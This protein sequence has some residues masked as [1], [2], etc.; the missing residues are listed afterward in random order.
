MI[1]PFGNLH[2][3]ILCIKGIVVL[4]LSSFTTI[5]STFFDLTILS[6]STFITFKRLLT[7]WE[8]TER[9]TPSCFV[10]FDISIVIVTRLFIVM[11]NRRTFYSL[12]SMVRISSSSIL[13]VRVTWEVAFSP[14]FRVVIIELRKSFWAFPIPRRLICGVLLV[15]LWAA[16][17][18]LSMIVRDL[19]WRAFVPRKKRARANHSHFFF[20][21]RSSLRHAH[22]P[23]WCFS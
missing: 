8:R 11:W 1:H 15:F 5:Y 10:H 20:A 6:D 13:E 19:H 22:C 12:S 3:T 4:C 16:L 23:I 2:P 7:K 17:S 18:F 9:I 21:G 14:T